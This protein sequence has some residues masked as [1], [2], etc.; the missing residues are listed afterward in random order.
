MKPT[1][2]L[3]LSLLAAALLVAGSIAA[4]AEPTTF[5]GIGRVREIKVIDQRIVIGG[6]RYVMPVEVAR[7]ATKTNGEPAVLDSGQVVKFHGSI[8]R[9]QKTIEAIRVL[10]DGQQ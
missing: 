9:G 4:A 10:R 3:W 2:R 6:Q 5:E 8:A 7:S 1:K